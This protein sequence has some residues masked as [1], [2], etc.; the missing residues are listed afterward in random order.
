[1]LEQNCTFKRP[2]GPLVKVGAATK[3]TLQRLTFPVLQEAPDRTVVF[4]AGDEFMDMTQ[5]HTVHIANQATDQSSSREQLRDT[6][7]RPGPPVSGLDQGFKDFLAGFWKPEEPE[8]SVEFLS[9][10]K[11]SYVL[12]TTRLLGF[13]LSTL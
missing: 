2:F 1:M 5:S 3:Q 12:T 13:Y 10:P 7:S 9:F 4:S 11:A 8:V 6:R